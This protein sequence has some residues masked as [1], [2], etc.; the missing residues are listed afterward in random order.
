MKKILGARLF[1]LNE[2]IILDI[3][4]DPKSPATP[5]PY[6]HNLYPFQIS[7]IPVIRKI[8]T[9]TQRDKPKIKRIRFF[10]KYLVLII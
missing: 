5:M 4:I 6:H 2:I 1:L 9:K 8:A 7:S 3:L 10:I